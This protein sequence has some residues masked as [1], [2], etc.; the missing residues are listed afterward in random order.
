MFN[1]F[2][3]VSSSIHPPT[4]ERKLTMK[5]SPPVLCVA[6]I[7]GILLA[8]QGPPPD[9]FGFDPGRMAIGP[10]GPPVSGAPF[11][12]V[13]TVEIQRT[14]ADGNT[15]QVQQQAKVY[16]DSQ[17]RVR[18]ESTFNSPSGQTQ[19][20]VSIF[21]PIAGYEAR[22]DPQ[23]SSAV[24]HPLPTATP[25][26]N[27]APPPPDGPIGSQSQTQDLGSDTINGLAATGTEIVATIPAGT[28]GNAQTL[29]IVKRVWVSTALRIPVLITSS[30]PRS[31]TSTMQLINV[32]QTEPDPTIFQIPS[33]Y[34]VVTESSLGPGPGGPPL[35]R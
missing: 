6:L 29:Q 19:P 9:A 27:G 13:Q 21:D 7:S 18:I 34:S 23:T 17:G 24:K 12:G 33:S 14:L 25:H 15:I 5:Y 22:L 3:I 31:G 2:E 4:Q 35:G 1:S 16:R 11:S 10:G 8:A 26:G 32:S 28:I 20:S 30:D